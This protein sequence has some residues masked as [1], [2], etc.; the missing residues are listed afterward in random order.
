MT[1]GAAKNWC[2]TK[3]NYT[4][5]DETTLRAL[6]DTTIK[7]LVVGKEIG[8][9]GTPHLQGFLQ[10]NDRKRRSQV[11]NI[12]GECHLTVARFT[13]NSITYCKKDGDFFEVGV[14]V[15][16]SNKGKRNDLADFME[17]V[18]A[19]E[20]DPVAL[21]ESHPEIAARYP[22]FFSSYIQDNAPAFKIEGEIVLRPWQA[23]LK[24]I[25][26]GPVDQR[27]INF[28]VD[29][30]GN[31]GKSW[32]SHYYCLHADDKAN[33]QVLLP[34]KKQDMAYALINEPRVIFLDCPR[35]KQGDFIQY[36][37]IEDVKNGY[38]FST[39]YES[40]AKRFPPPHIVILMNEE[41]DMT[42]FSQ[43]RYNIT[44]LQH[45]VFNM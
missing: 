1:S 6:S 44:R 22:R 18:K 26:D 35:S 30:T 29:E 19:G 21:R 34:G 3:N 9:Q 16:K 20:R 2:F 10:L 25:L 23:A 43:D 45:N 17:T 14:F 8:E 32:F 41:P 31:M 37:F 4:V 36:D 33:C 40:R 5:E 24:T 15:E 39:K 27:T 11:K 13:Q 42:K 38:V 7:Y 12:L 28:Y